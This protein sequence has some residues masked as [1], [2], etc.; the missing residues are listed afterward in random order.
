MGRAKKKSDYVPKVGEKVIVPLD[1]GRCI[2]TVKE[3]TSESAYV[4]VTGTT[5]QF[6]LSRVLPHTA[7]NFH[8]P[9]GR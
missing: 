5:M 2:G 6:A 8:L 1:S 3:V 9:E 7:E 4:D